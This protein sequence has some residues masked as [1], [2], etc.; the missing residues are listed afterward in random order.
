MSDT[1]T[2]VVDL[3]ERRAAARA[4]RGTIALEDAEILAQTEWPGDQYVV[5]LDLGD[6]LGMIRV[7]DVGHGFDSARLQAEDPLPQDERGLAFVEHLNGVLVIV[8]LTWLA[9]AAIQGVA[10]GVILLNPAEV[11][12]YYGEEQRLAG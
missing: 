1:S 10:N 9:V 3:E 8:M 6:R 5:R 11:A 2:G 7:I 4:Q 12:R